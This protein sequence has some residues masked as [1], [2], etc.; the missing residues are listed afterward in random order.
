MAQIDR[1]GFDNHFR[2]SGFVAV[3]RPSGE[4]IVIQNPKMKKLTLNDKYSIDEI[5]REL[6]FSKKLLNN[7]RKCFG[8]SLSLY[9]L[10]QL[11][12]RDFFPCKG[13]GQKSW[14]EFKNAISMIDI[15]DKSV[16]IV[17]QLNQNKIVVEIDISKPFSEV[18]INLSYIIKNLVYRD[19][20]PHH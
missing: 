2:S 12:Q 16:K 6:N 14:Y 4:L 11:K 10:S 18:I 20:T 9:E 5:A 8:E 1:C 13:L 7:L 19:R 15:P 3:C 17:D